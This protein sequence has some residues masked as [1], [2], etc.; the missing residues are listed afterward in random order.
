MWPFFSEDMRCITWNIRGLVGSVLQLKE[1]RIQSQI[2]QKKLLDNNI[3]CLQEVHGKDE[4]L[5][6]IQVLAPRFRLCCTFLP[7]DESARG[8]AI[9]IHKDV[10]LEETIVTHSITCQG[11]DHLV[12]IRSGRHSLVNVDLHFEPELTLR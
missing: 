4:F 9:C 5:Q 7:D 2:S 10:L 11:R 3:I 1:Q 8:T 12:N 6:A